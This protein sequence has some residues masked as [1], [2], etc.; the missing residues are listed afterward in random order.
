MSVVGLRGSGMTNRKYL[1]VSELPAFSKE[2]SERFGLAGV[3]VV[4]GLAAE[5]LGET[6]QADAGL[7]GGAADPVLPDERF[8]FGA[9]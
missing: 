4:A 8:E 6:R 2:R 7:A 9:D 1:W 5:P 3:E